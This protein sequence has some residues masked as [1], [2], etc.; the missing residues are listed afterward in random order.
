VITL[1][2]MSMAVSYQAMRAF[3]AAGAVPSFYQGNFAPA[4]MMACG[5]G[6]VEPLASPSPLVDFLQVKRNE[7][8][9]ALLP[10]SLKSTQVTWN[11]T[12]LYLYGSSAM[13][14]RLTGISWTALDGLVAVLGGFT[15]AMLYALFRLVAFRWTAAA[16]ALLLTL[17]P[18]NL[19]HLLSLRDYSKAPFVLAAILILA[20]LVS[21]PMRVASM[22]ALAGL[23][24]AVVG[25]GWGFRSDLSVM[26]PFGVLVVLGFLP[27]GLRANAVRNGLAGAILLS[28][29]FITAWPAL[30]GLKTAGCQFHLGLLGLT[31]PMTTGLGVSPSIYRFGDQFLDTFVALKVSDYSERVMGV[32]VP[33]LCSPQY[34]AASRRLFMEMAATFSADLVA[35]AYGSMLMILK[36]GLAIPGEGVEPVFPSSGIATKAYW[37][38]HWITTPMAPVGPLLVLGAIGLAWAH[39]TRVGLALTIFVLFLSGYP[40]IEFE[41]RHWF[42]LR[43]IPW[44]AGVLIAGE[45]VRPGPRTWSRGVQWRAAGGIV[46][47]VAALVVLLAATR[48]VQE[49]TVVSLIS[50]YIGAANEDV[51]I[52]RRDGT[53]VD[54]RWQPYD[55][56]SPPAHRASDLLIVTLDAAQCS[57]PAAG[58]LTL[59][60]RYDSDEAS[61][62][63][64]TAIDVPRPLVGTE[65]TRVFIPVFL[66]GAGA[67]TYLRFSGFDMVDA[68]ATCV[69]H[70]ARVTDRSALPLWIQIQVAA[71][72]RRQHLYQTIRAPRWVRGMAARA[73]S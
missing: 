23:Y 37:L 40:A 61:H 42:H 10:D 15:T 52:E 72:W 6:F 55:M 43:F 22:L 71:D 46:G 13:V 47:V 58:S 63:M 41:E 38:L 34:E 65:A 28:V 39:S 69:G 56:A 60:V 33:T 7:F 51:P 14:W 64:S 48:L 9:C 2:A 20:M 16:V 57:T 21:R 45:A 66:A 70:V 17:S 24:G 68:P 67:Q 54:V 62:D 25:F 50:R 1:S 5:R 12:W 29:F 49:H 59:K 18:A 8:A 26:V 3:R 4:V 30:R 11:P 36:S 53:S 44:W 35:H 73:S 19:T 32:D 27:G 31:T